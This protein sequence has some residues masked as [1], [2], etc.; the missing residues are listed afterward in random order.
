MYLMKTSISVFICLV[1]FSVIHSPLFAAQGR[2]PNVVV[3]VA[4]DLGY[5]D[6]GVHGNK[7]VD[8]TH[9]DSLAASGVRFTTGYASGCVCS[10]TRAGLLT[11]RYQTRSGHDSNPKRQFGLDEKEVTIAQ[12]FKAAGY[13]TGMV[14]KWHLGDSKEQHPMSR[15]FDEFYGILPH[16]I[17][18]EG[19]DGEDVVVYRGWEAVATPDDY[20]LGFGEEAAKFIERHRSEPFFLYVPFTAVHSPHIAPEKYLDRVK[21]PN[22]TPQRR[23]YLAM[24]VTLDD[25]VGCILAEL[26]ENKLE[27][28]T[29]VFFFADNGGPER[30]PDNTPLRGNKWTLWEG[31]IRVPYFASW[32]GKIPA[33]RVSHEPVISIDIA[34]TA[35]AAAGIEPQSDWKL[36]GANLLPLL[37]GQQEQ[38]E[39]EAL[40]WR[41]GVQFAVRQGDWKLVKPSLDD[42][43]MLFN[44]ASD[45]GEA[46]NLAEKEPQKVAELTKLWQAWDTKNIPPRWEDQRWNG[47]EQRKNRKKAKRAAK[48]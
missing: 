24:L 3:I 37:T 45:I 5:A 11:G 36:D 8:T 9:I 48:A 14:G 17:G 18:K 21:D 6:L 33:G 31:G 44:L 19:P 42:E 12:R 7:A 16:G 15:G 41:F 27:E 46:N 4:D 1:G 25:A 29:L 22:V 34:S 40:Y 39:R 30:A 38:L 20:T 47:G 43:P 35:F 32:K 10:P 13:K 23:R 26:R 2:Q 28:N